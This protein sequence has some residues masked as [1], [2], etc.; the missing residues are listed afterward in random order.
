[1]YVNNITRKDINTLFVMFTAVYS[2]FARLHNCFNIV[3]ADEWI[4]QMQS[5]NSTICQ[6]LYFGLDRWHMCTL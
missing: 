5:A 3:V 4:V 1:M 6:Y 2:K